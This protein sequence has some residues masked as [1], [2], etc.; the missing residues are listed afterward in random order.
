MDYKEIYKKTDCPKCKEELKEEKIDFNLKNLL[1]EL[2]SINC[3]NCKKDVLFENIESHFLETC[4]KINKIYFCNLCKK[5]FFSEEKENNNNKNDKDKNKEI[6]IDIDYNYNNENDNYMINSHRKNCEGI[7]Y[8]CIFCNKIDNK[9]LMEKH[10]I[11]EC[12]G[13]VYSCEKCGCDVYEKFSH[14]HNDF[15]CENLL[16][17][18]Y[19]LSKIVN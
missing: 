5:E 7:L 2:I 10:L 12:K 14:V 1:N 13:K 9:F 4:E 16:I 3:E 18:N 8:E 19:L 11:D 15:F 6:D 17:I